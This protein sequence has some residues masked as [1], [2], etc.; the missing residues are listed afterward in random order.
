MKERQK[1]TKLIKSLFK[2]ELR[3]EDL[4]HL[5]EIDI[6]KERMKE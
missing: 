5:T 4:E 2:N 3:R 6:V 1:N